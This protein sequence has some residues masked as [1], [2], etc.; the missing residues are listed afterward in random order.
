MRPRLQ[1]LTHETIEHVVAEGYDLL[2]D[3]GVRVHSERALHL[4]AKHGAEV[5][6][7][8]QVVRIPADLARQAVETVPFSFHLYDTDGQPTVHYGSD[9]VHFDPGS[10]AIEILDHGAKHS[11]PP[12]T[13]DFVRFVKL[14]DGLGSDD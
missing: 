9:D 14:A 2:S 3:P 4:L 12:I 1:F 10:A 13:A 7:E 5:D 8:A 11:R 6:F